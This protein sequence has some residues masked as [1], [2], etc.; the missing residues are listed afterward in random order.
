LEGPRAVGERKMI[1]H[2]I[3]IG[4][5]DENAEFAGEFVRIAA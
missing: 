1:L 2:R 4:A 3:C 5:G